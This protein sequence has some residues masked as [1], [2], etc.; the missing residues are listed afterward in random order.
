MALPS[1]ALIGVVHLPPLPGSPRSAMTVDAIV[2]RATDQ[3]RHLVDAGFDGVVIENFGDYPFFGERVE[4]HTA[5]AVGLVARAV[6]Q[7]VD[8]PVGVNML[9]NDAR[10]GMA[11][12]AMS[13]ASFIRVNVHTGVYATDQGVLEGKAAETMRYRSALGVSVAVFADVHV[14]HA[15]PLA[16][17]AHHDLA[18]AAEETAYRGMADAL[19]VTG[20]TTARPA[21][22]EDVKRVKQAVPDRPVFVGSGVTAETVAAVLAE[23]DGVIVGSALKQGGQTEADLDADRVKAFVQAARG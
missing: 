17:T 19:I 2:D 23:A 21:E 13:G 22:L 6:V 5:V 7:A 3:A 16:G 8:R 9:R 12:A 18:R 4:V 11:V 10:S 20:P 15:K 14:K 1:R